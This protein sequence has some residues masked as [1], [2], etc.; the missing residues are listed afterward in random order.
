MPNELKFIEA[1]VVT[2][3]KLEHVKD[4]VSIIGEGCE[5]CG[6]LGAVRGLLG[7]R[8][9]AGVS[10]E[11]EQVIA[12]LL[13]LVVSKMVADVSRRRRHLISIRV[14]QVFHQEI[15]RIFF[16]M[17]LFGLVCLLQIRSACG[18]SSGRPMA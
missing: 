3:V 18:L 9:L 5:R 8:L 7:M 13:L 10:G 4:G 11:V 17:F 2:V 6:I 1:I 15:E 12:R 16:R 14:A